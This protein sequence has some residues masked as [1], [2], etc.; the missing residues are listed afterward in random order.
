M[1]RI[2]CEQQEREN[3]TT[4]NSKGQGKT[5]KINKIKNKFMFFCGVTS[6]FIL[7]DIEGPYSSSALEYFVR[8]EQNVTVDRYFS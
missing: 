8:T 7:M 5:L 3:E 2:K 6:P 4:Y 1:H